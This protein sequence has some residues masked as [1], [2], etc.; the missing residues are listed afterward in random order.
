MKDHAAFGRHVGWRRKRLMP[1]YSRYASMGA[2]GVES[3]T[4]NL[5]AYLDRI[6]FTGQP[7]PTLNCLQAI[8]HAHPLA[9][10]FENLDSF[11]GQPVHLA[12]EH[13]F[14]KLVTQGR[15]G[16]CFEQNRLLANALA[17]IG[18]NVT[19]HA[20]R[21]VWH[22]LDKQAMPRTHKL[23]KVHID[24]S[25]YIADAGF[26]GLTMTAPVS[27][28]PGVSQAS[29]HEN[30]RIDNE[31]EYYRISAQLGSDWKSMYLFDLSTYIAPDFELANYYVST[32]PESRFVH[33]LVAAR[34][35]RNGRH[36]LLDNH[37][38]KYSRDGQKTEK[39]IADPDELMALLMDIFKINLDSVDRTALQTRLAGII[40]RAPEAAE[41]AE[42]PA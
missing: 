37:Y 23:L 8:H 2:S 15:G 39:V 35:F 21:V 5:H 19:T 17:D 16:Y 42:N 18:F 4:M 11:L 7:E 31:D 36:A 22:G 28:V 38:T 3:A 14:D 9:I 10:P 33:H 40:S 27:L 13:V 30:F 1:T 41:L 12:P 32:H 34:P 25:D 26:G 24:G 6:G 20:A 29:P